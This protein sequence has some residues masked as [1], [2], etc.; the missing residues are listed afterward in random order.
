VLGLFSFVVRTG[1]TAPFT[2][3]RT[4]KI[5]LNCS[6]SF[7]AVNSAKGCVKNFSKLFTCVCTSGKVKDCN[8][9]ILRECLS[10]MTS[11]LIYRSNNVIKARAANDMHVWI[12]P[13]ICLNFFL[14]PCNVD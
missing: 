12:F 13:L 5:C 11:G 3:T 7:A 8:F 6:F 1:I 4:Y 9:P 14:V 10:L 2:F